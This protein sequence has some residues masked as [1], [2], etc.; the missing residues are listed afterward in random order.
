MD[1]QPLSLFSCAGLRKDFDSSWARQDP[2]TTRS[3]SQ[4]CG[5][6]HRRPGSHSASQSGLVNV[7]KSRRV[8]MPTRVSEVLCHPDVKTL[9]EHLRVTSTSTAAT[10]KESNFEQPHSARQMQSLAHETSHATNIGSR[11]SLGVA[12][13][14]GPQRCPE[15]ENIALSNVIAM[16][17]DLKNQ[18][19]KLQGEALE[20]KPQLLL[21]ARLQAQVL[22][23]QD[24][25]S[26][27]KKEFAL[28]KKKVFVLDQTMEDDCLKEIGQ[29]SPRRALRRDCLKSVVRTTLPTK[30]PPSCHSQSRSNSPDRNRSPSRR[31]EARLRGC[32]LSQMISSAVRSLSPK[33]KHPDAYPSQPFCDSPSRSISP[34]PIAH[35]NASLQS[36]KPIAHC[37]GIK[38]H[39]PSR[40]IE[41]GFAPKLLN[42]VA[43]FVDGQIQNLELRMAS[44]EQWQHGAFANWRQATVPVDAV[45]GMC[46]SDLQMLS[47]LNLVTSSI[48]EMQRL[49]SPSAQSGCQLAS[50]SAPDVKVHAGSDRKQPSKQDNAV[51]CQRRGKSSWK[52]FFRRSKSSC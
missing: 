35:R 34:E 37:N 12:I 40:R 1:T 31:M 32:R 28:V 30:Q 41:S 14:A 3:S 33:K 38:S 23:L 48:E 51:S 29:I 49:Q 13:S 22:K 26:D 20:Q 10:L 21:I 24:E 15:Q 6:G 52:Q 47:G 36:Q 25:V 19:S 44:M 27:N 5:Q 46:A 18:V 45:E 4:P 11:V 42:N 50:C 7:S 8:S 39:S 43:C 2:S 16:T 17:M 9:D